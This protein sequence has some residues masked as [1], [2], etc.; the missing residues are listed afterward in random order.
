[1]RPYQNWFL[2]ELSHAGKPLLEIYVSV[3]EGEDIH[4]IARALHAL[5]PDMEVNPWP[6]DARTLQG[7]ATAEA[8]ERVFGFQ[9][10]RVNLPRWDALKSCY[11]GVHPDGYFWESVVDWSITPP[12]LAGRLAGVGFSQPGTND[13]GGLDNIRYDLPPAI[14]EV[15]RMDDH[16]R[17]FLVATVFARREAEDRVREL[18]SSAH[19]QTYFITSRQP[20]GG[21][22]GE[23]SLAP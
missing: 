4:E 12:E 11:D 20:R 18:E 1:M 6:R 3:G 21:M 8:M 23:D 15:T 2:S 7:D 22:G 10:Q 14:Y 9:L 13:N 19:K 5:A 17:T 16:G